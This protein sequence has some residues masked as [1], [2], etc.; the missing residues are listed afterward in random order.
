[1]IRTWEAEAVTPQITTPGT[2]KFPGLSSM[3]GQRIG[4]MEWFSMKEVDQTLLSILTRQA[5]PSIGIRSPVDYGSFEL[6]SLCP[7]MPDK[8]PWIVHIP[9]MKNQVRLSSSV[10]ECQF[11]IEDNF[12]V[13]AGWSRKVIQLVEHGIIQLKTFPHK[14]PIGICWD[15]TEYSVDE[16]MMFLYK[17]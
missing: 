8:F 3:S 14:K 10:R 4:K 15:R 16:M 6:R 9:W 2:R 12:Y 5:C 1:M 13:P 11:R 7:R 17:F